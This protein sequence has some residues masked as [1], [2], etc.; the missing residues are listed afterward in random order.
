MS[1]GQRPGFPNKKK[2]VCSMK[3]NTPPVFHSARPTFEEAAAPLSLGHLD[4]EELVSGLQRFSLA[5][6][7][8]QTDQLD[9]FC[10]MV[11][12]WNRRMNL[13]AITDPKGMTQKHLLDS[14]ALLWAYP[15]PS[16]SRLMD[17]GAGAGFPSVPLLIAR[18]DLQGVLLD[19]LNK[20]ILFLKAVCQALSIAGEPVHS[21]A[22]EASR[23]PN[24]R[25]SFD[26]VTARAVAPMELL[27]E[28]CLPFVK[29]GGCFAAMK[30]AAG[31]QELELALPI[32]NQLG[33]QVEKI[34]PYSLTGDGENARCVII[35]RK[36]RQ[37]SR[38]FPRNTA[39]QK[40]KKEGNSRK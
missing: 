30:G 24:W 32:I 5:L 17:V 4:R 36:I 22:E 14:L 18:P 37:T 8:E 13:T 12:D 10:G 34:V 2:A 23:Q 19:S 16:G 39:K 26:L 38:D 27:S 6:S 7:S 33:G 31:Q 11:A 3:K 29:I 20:R 9:Y 25:E 35:V 28:L 1:A 40:G 21:R 15:I